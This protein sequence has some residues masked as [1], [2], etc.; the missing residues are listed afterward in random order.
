MVKKAQT[1]VVVLLLAL[2]VFGGLFAFLLSIARTVVQTDYMNL[3]TSNLL[4]SVLRKD[5]GYSGK[6]CETV[7]DLVLCKFGISRDPYCE[8]YSCA[9]LAENILN[10]T[11]EQFGSVK[12]G[13]DYFLTAKQEGKRR[14]LDPDGKP[15]EL[16]IGNEE[17]ENLRKDK[18]VAAEILQR[19]DEHGPFILK[20][21]LC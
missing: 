16:K 4:I 15:I 21:I 9:Y 17:L 20:I 14:A 3:Y 6:D 1:T 2:V 12:K 13:Y 7:S 18:F 11:M 5:T 19:T 10:E 8:E